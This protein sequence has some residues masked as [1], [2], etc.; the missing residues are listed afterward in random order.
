MSF[1]M[2]DL[3]CESILRDGFEVCRRYPYVI[4][5]V[6]G[7]LTRPFAEKKYGVPELEKIKKIIMN[8]E[9]S[10]VHSFNLVAANLPC[11]S[12][13]LSDDRESTERAHMGNYRGL[14]TV[15]YS[16]PEQIAQTIQVPAFTAISYNA[17]TGA[18]A[19][20][21]SVN[22]FA[23]HLGL[24]VHDSTGASFP[25][26]G[27]II[28]DLGAKQVMISTDCVIDIANP[29]DIR[30]TLDY[31]MY[32]QNGNVEEVQL[33]L[34]I[35]TKEALLTKYLYTL[36][37]YF[38]ISRKNDLIRRGLQLN[39]YTGSDFN[40]NV[41]YVGDVVYT[42]FFH[43]IGT[44]Q[45]SWRADKVHLIDSIDVKPTMIP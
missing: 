25:I 43:V 31:D 4:D 27:G 32:R 9:V 3:I 28:N 40:R 37:K 38:M 35:H 36:V 17:V 22:L 8:K 45:H 42:R 1:K 10:I 23:I 20:P 41:E 21:D 6:F 14:L 30:T 26:L 13:Q 33:I 19:V 16:T 44:V 18:L 12:I 34:G 29:I 7:E 24:I 39:T 15:P 5:D 2:P 11:I